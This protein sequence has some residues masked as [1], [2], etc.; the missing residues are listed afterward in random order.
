MLKKVAG[1]LLLATG[2]AGLAWIG[3]DETRFLEPAQMDERPFPLRRV[4]VPEL[5][6]EK[7]VQYVGKLKLRIYVRA[8]G[9]LDHIDASEST[10]PQPIVDQ[11]VQAFSAPG[12]HAGSK[13]GRARRG[14]KVVELE[15]RADARESRI[16]PER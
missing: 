7:G 8:S 1:A 14:V 15:Y 10:L 12:W 3:Y 11:A 9:A 16:S 5:V 2:V 13:N 4:D 6:D